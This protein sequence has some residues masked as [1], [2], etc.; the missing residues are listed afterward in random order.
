MKKIYYTVLPGSTEAGRRPGRLG[1]WATAAASS[2]I[3]GLIGALQ[4]MLA[5]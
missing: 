3:T 2:A 1:N 4:A 5:Q